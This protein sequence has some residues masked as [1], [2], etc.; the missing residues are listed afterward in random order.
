MKTA[1][2]QDQGR[3]TM[4][5]KVE[6]QDPDSHTGTVGLKIANVGNTK[7]HKSLFTISLI[8]K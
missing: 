4:G 2:L 5:R 3:L 1:A 8:T 7:N 6:R